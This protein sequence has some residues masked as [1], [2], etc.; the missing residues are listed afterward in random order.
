MINL[1]VSITQF[2][3]FLSLIYITVGAIVVT[4]TINETKHLNK[5]TPHQ[6][7]S[8]ILFWPLLTLNIETIDRLDNYIKKIK[9]K[10]K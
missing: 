1:I 4:F 7:I 8:L 2:L 10:K 5:Y 3:G 6:I 9:Q